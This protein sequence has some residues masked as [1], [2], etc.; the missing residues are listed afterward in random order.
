MHTRKILKP[1]T[2]WKGHQQVSL[3]KN[4]NIVQ[5]K[6]H[7]LVAVMFIPNPNNLPII[8]H[9]DENPLNNC[10]DN[11]E[12]C[13]HKHNVQYSYD[14]HRNERY[15]KCVKAGESGKGKKKAPFSKE[16]R[17]NMSKAKKGKH[18]TEEHKRRLS[19]ATKGA[20]NP[21][22]KK[23]VCIET[24]EVFGTI[25]EA[26]KWCGGNIKQF[27]SGKT[28]Y[29]GKHPETDEELHWMY[30]EDWLKLQEDKREDDIL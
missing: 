13:T 7:R 16:H 4:G 29:A 11:L 15:Q 14:L 28:K 10:V 17:N 22:A 30:Y 9:L 19:N 1:G 5:F 25:K 12:W 8:N 3:C 27:L 18:F 21:R 23:V 6:V 24:M 20:N 2:L 26:S